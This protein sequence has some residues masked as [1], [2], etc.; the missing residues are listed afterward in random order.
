MRSQSYK[1]KMVYP[2]PPPPPPPLMNLPPPSG[3]SIFVEYHQ[4]I[5]EKSQLH[6]EDSLKRAREEKDSF[7]EQ[8]LYLK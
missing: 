1:V 6:V 8:F 2:P 7:M 5:V 3:K 4:L